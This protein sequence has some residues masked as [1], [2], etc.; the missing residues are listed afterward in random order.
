MKHCITIDQG[1]LTFEI[2]FVIASYIT[3]VYILKFFTI[4]GLGRGLSF[5]SRI[6]VCFLCNSLRY[7]LF[8]VNFVCL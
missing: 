7:W 8:K 5:A 2:I 1:D 6:K 4:T 3:L